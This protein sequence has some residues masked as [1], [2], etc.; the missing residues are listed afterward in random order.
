MLQKSVALKSRVVSH[1]ILEGG[2]RML[3]NILVVSIILITIIITI[4]LEE[5]L[6]RAFKVASKKDLTS[7]KRNKS[8]MFLLIIYFI[9][10][11]L[12]TI[13][14]KLNNEFV[15]LNPL[16]IYLWTSIL[17]GLYLFIKGFK[18]RKNNKASNEYLYYFLL[19]LWSFIAIYIFYLVSNI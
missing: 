5:Y 4:F 19:A 17:F 14:V 9:G 2:E 11:F 13:K 1:H 7:I 10:L 12:S 8:A 18:V 6:K 15:S 3:K 16:N